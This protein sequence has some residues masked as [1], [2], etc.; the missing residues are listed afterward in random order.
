MRPTNGP[1]S[2]FLKHSE[3]SLKDYIP[4]SVNNYR[5]NS[6]PAIPLSVADIRVTNDGTLGDVHV[7]RL[8]ITASHE[9]IS[10]AI[11]RDANVEV[12]GAEING[13]PVDRSGSARGQSPTA[14]RCSFGRRRRQD[15]I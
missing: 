4:L 3:T 7:L 1:P 11:P 8:H 2:S 9:G 15:S 5:I 14:W 13:K 10:L 12:V 6:A